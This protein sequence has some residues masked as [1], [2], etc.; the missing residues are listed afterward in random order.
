MHTSKISI[1]VILL[2]LGFL[3]SCTNDAV[4]PSNNTGRGGSLTRFAI[5]QNYLYVANN[6]QI[7]VYDISAN[8]FSLLRTIPT[9]LGLETIQVRSPY[10]YLGAND[11][12]YIYSIV[13]PELPK[14]V[15]RYA[16]IVACD[17]V[18]VQGNR[19]YVTLKSSETSNT[20]NRGV[21][22]LEIIDITNPQNPSLIKSYDMTSP[23]GLAIDGNCLFVCEGENG[24]KMFD[25]TNDIITPVNFLVIHAYDVIA[26][27]AT[28][29]LTGK[30]G[31]FQ[32][33]YDCSDASLNLISKIPVDREGL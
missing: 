22:N 12:M 1:W 4:G 24:L 30:D 27:N 19:A 29:T 8:K 25:V 31:V 28:L 33:S 2:S 5:N 14:F 18:V 6:S 13:D 15:F 17:P 9:N 10:L 20:C 32:Y 11:G 21:N 3:L 23:G 16:H 7:S 26:Y